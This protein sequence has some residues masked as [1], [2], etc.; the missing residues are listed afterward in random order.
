MDPSFT[1]TYAD[2]VFSGAISSTHELW[3]T[4][5]V[6]GHTHI[7][8]HSNPDPVGLHYCTGSVRAIHFSST[9]D[10]FFSGDSSGNLFLID[11]ATNATVFSHP[12]AHRHSIECIDHISSSVYVVGD[13]GGA[14]R[15][16]DLRADNIVHNYSVED[17]YVSDLAVVDAKNFAATHGNGVASL[18][19]VSMGKRKQYYQQE[20]DDFTSLTYSPSSSE[21][22]ISS[23]K[24]QIYVAKYP[25]LDFVGQ[26]P[27]NS[28]SPI[29]MIRVLTNARNRAAVAHEDGTVHIADIAPNR[30]IFAFRAHGPGLRG[31]TVTGTELM[32]W[33][34]EKTVKKW[35]LAE[36][37][38][39]EPERRPRPKHARSRK[40]Q[41]GVKVTEKEDDFFADF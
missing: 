9:N 1:A 26:A 13:T 23:S 35:D 31:G 21:L 22:M 15:V 20:N 12:K 14:I 3:V 38:E 30:G 24:P 25:S 37:A 5:T 41:K 40:R 27:G 8:S 36:V 28:K 16:W 11:I 7:Y 10:S 18:F 19:S 4:G 29:V 2:E 39:L 33:S 17:D 32:T 34:G 6:A